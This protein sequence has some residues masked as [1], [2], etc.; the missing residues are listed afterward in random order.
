MAFNFQGSVPVPL[1]L[2][3]SLVTEMAPTAVPEGIS[4]DCQDNVFAPG[5]T[6]SRPALQKVFAQPFPPVPGGTIGPYGTITYAKSYVTPTGDIQNLYFDSNGWLWMEDL[7]NTPGTY[8]ALY[9]AAPGSYCKSV[10]AFGREYIAISDKLHGTGIALQW[11]G[12]WLDRVTQDGPGTAPTVISL[13]LPSV[14]MPSSTAPAPALT[15]TAIYP[16]ATTLPYYTQIGIF[17]QVP[18]TFPTL[19]Q[20]VT[21]SGTGTAFDG[22]VATVTAL[23]ANGEIIISAYFPLSQSAYVG[24]G[25]LTVGSST[26]DVTMVRQNNVVTVLTA[27]PHLL[28][29]GYQAQITG[30]PAAGVGGGIATVAIDNEDD[31]GVALVT[32]ATAHGL[33]PGQQVSLNGIGPIAVGGTIVSTS[34]QGGIVTVVTTT[35]HGL[36][37][38]ANINTAGVGDTSFN[39]DVAVLSIPSP[40]SFTF[41]Q[42]DVTNATSSGGTL[43]LSWPVPDTG[44][45][46]YYEVIAA[47]TPDSFQIAINYGDGTWTTG[48]VTLAWDGTFFVSAVP[49]PTSF[50]YQQYGPDA[51]TTTVGTVTPYGQVSP[52]QHQMQVMFLTRNGYI[53][54]PSPPIEF[55]ANGGQYLSITNIPVGPAT[56]IV[57]RILAFTSAQG[58]FFYYIPVAARDPQ[59]GQLVSTA[60]QINDNVTTAIVL[61][62]SDNTLLAAI[63]IS[64]PGNSLADQIVI[65]GALG[66]GF[67]GSRLITWG[68]RN[69]IQNLL[70]MSMSGGHNPNLAIGLENFPTGWNYLGPGNTGALSI[71]DNPPGATWEIGATQAGPC[72]QLQQSMYLDAYQ[73][74][75]ATP[76]M[77][78]TFRARFQVIST[79]PVPITK[80]PPGSVLVAKISSASTGFS[81]TASIDLTQA[82]FG[83]GLAY[84]QANFTEETPITIPS[85]LVLTI[86]AEQSTNQGE[87]HVLVDEMSVI[88]TDTPYTDTILYGSYVN[89]PEAFDGESGQFGAVDDTRKVMAVAIIRS[90]L[91]LL[92]LEPS[93]RLHQ[94]SQNGTTEPVGW[95][96]DEIGANC[97]ILSAFSLTTSQADDASAGGGEEWFAWA[98]SSGARIFG[99]DQPWKISQEIQPDWVGALAANAPWSTAQ[100]INW[101][102][103][104]TVWALNDP[105]ARVI[106]FGLPTGEA[107][108][109]NLIYP[110]NYREL[111]TPYQIAM[112]PPVHTSFAGKLIATD[113]TRKWTRWNLAMNGAV[114]MYR[115]PGVLSVVFLNGNGQAPGAAP[116]FGNVYTL[117]SAKYTDDDYGQIRPYYTTYFFVNHEAEIAL[118]LGAARKTLKYAQ[119]IQSGVG[120][121]YLTIFCDDLSN[122]YP[123][124]FSRYLPLISTHD[125]PYQGGSAYG[126]RLA[127]KFASYPLNPALSL[128]NGFTLNKVVAAL[129]PTT[130][131]P[132]RGSV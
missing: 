1:A 87:F 91:Y 73:V 70:N 96:V 29:V 114:L 86:Y 102:A 76:S 109:P 42:N 117:N 11:T 132:V 56:S 59:T 38:G 118:Q 28:L 106:Y 48:T 128:D 40:T 71:A 77:Q 2:F 112:S 27:T 78:Y 26:P 85:D 25:T 54:R 126:E 101:A 41:L 130:H 69:V 60:T 45:P 18:A 49:S 9:H 22:T 124:A 31:P 129:A 43:T 99:G 95:E 58:A 107:T 104:L 13:A 8:T 3:G 4:V 111:D 89:N 33:V 53:T 30:V 44:T 17:I 61:D 20:Q 5:S 82:A 52:G 68:Q 66:F 92:T 94:T 74:P 63:G 35:P 23:P 46:Y 12:Q 127:L 123:I 121:M 75:I 37:V 10:T 62:F 39:T 125:T 51:T 122:P 72:G 47:P 90:F 55:T 15:I 6:S 88:Y 113:N 65:D 100:G 32:T 80:T 83:S 14:Q 108:A 103:A 115:T 81:A 34:R 19:G 119:A 16:I 105:V 36:T 57:A 98:S 97:G 120:Q 64:Q 67:F 84:G 79:I 24:S 110:V 7:T 50:Q 93:G 21:I 116:G 131:I